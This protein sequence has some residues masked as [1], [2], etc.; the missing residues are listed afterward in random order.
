MSK[1]MYNICHHSRK[2]FSNG[3]SLAILLSHSCLQAGDN[4]FTCICLS[5]CMFVCLSF[6]KISQEPVDIL[7]FPFTEKSLIQLE[8]LIRF[9]QRSNSRWLTDLNECT[10]ADWVITYIRTG[11]ID[12]KFHFVR[13]ICLALQQIVQ[14]LRYQ[15]YKQHYL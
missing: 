7:Q 2:L 14:I 3:K 15:Q 13:N 4:V 9:C 8:E 11:V 1:F 6:T 12:L 10:K 5:V